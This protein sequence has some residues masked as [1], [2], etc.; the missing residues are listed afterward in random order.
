MAVNQDTTRRHNIN[1]NR[2]TEGKHIQLT[3]LTSA[4]VKYS[5][6]VQMEKHNKF[7]CFHTRY[8]GLLLW[9]FLD[10]LDCAPHRHHQNSKKQGEFQKLSERICQR[11]L[12]LFWWTL[13]VG[14]SFICAPSVYTVSLYVCKCLCYL[15]TQCLNTNISRTRH[16]PVI[17]IYLFQ[18][19]DSPVFR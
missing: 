16:C 2:A 9:P 17:T 13:Y 18:L 8:E 4:H 5:T 1:K 19:C 11:A 14:F 6:C 15:I 3:I 7:K 10:W 12:R